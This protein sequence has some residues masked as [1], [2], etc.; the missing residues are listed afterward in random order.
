MKLRSYLDQDQ[1]FDQKAEGIHPGDLC[2]CYAP[3]STPTLYRSKDD[4]MDW[5][6]HGKIPPAE[7]QPRYLPN[8]TIVMFLGMEEIAGYLWSKILYHD[9]TFYVMIQFRKYTNPNKVSTTRN[10][11]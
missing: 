8:G 5:W 10:L 7:Y 3:K 6:V 1:N 4:I 2:V 11:I 9:R